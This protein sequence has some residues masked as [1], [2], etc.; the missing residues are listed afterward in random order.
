ML[1]SPSNAAHLNASAG[2]RKP[3]RRRGCRLLSRAWHWQAVGTPLFALMNSAPHT[4]PRRRRLITLGT[5]T[6]PEITRANRKGTRKRLTARARVYHAQDAPTLF[7]VTSSNP[8]QLNGGHSDVNPGHRGDR[9][10]A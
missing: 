7:Y 10:T 2:T 5:T 3:V 4:G 8:K 9:D 6:G 1:E